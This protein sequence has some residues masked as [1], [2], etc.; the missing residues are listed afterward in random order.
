MTCNEE[1]K[2]RFNEEINNALNEAKQ[3][4]ELKNKLEYIK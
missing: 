4:I 3:A 2:I 1:E